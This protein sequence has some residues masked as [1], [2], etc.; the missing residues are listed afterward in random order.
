MEWKISI[1]KPGD[2]VRVKRDHY[3]HHGIYVGNGEVIHFTG[4]N[5]DGLTKPTEVLVRKTS[6]QFFLKDGVG[7][8]AIYSRKERRT[9][10]KPEEIV[11]LA[12]ERIGEGN[13]NIVSNNCEHFV[14]SV[15]FK[16]VKNTRKF[17]H[18]FHLLARIFIK[19]TGYLVFWIVIT[20][21]YFYASK[22]AKKESKKIKGGAII[23]SN[24]TSIFDYYI[25]V[26]KHFFHVIHTMVA[27]VVYSHKSLAHLCR[28]L[29][30]I[31]V[32]R[33]DPGN[34]KAYNEAKNY[35]NRG[36]TILIFPEGHLE[37]KA[38]TLE[39]MKASAIKLAFETGKPIIPYFTLGNYGLFKRTK[40]IVGEKIYV[41]EL[42][43]KNVL[44]DSDIKK[45]QEYLKTT[46]NKLKHQLNCM[47]KYK[48]RSLFSR[49][50]YLQDFLKITSIPIGYCILRARKIYIGDKKKIKQAMKE[51]VILAP[52]H[53]SM[54]DVMFMYL[55]FF[56]RRIRI[57]A[58]N[59]I[60]QVKFLA[61]NLD[62]SGVIKYNRE[63]PGGFDFA[64]YKET[65]GILEGNGAVVIFPQGHIVKDGLITET[66]KPG[67]AMHS[68]KHNAPVI[69]I[70]FAD[71]TK[72]IK[73]NRIIIGDP[74]YPYDYIDKD[75]PVNNE[76]IEK[77]NLLLTKKMQDLQEISVKYRRKA[78]QKRR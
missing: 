76:N 60:W 47:L 45:V 30:N 20:P 48:T 19:V 67:V 58:L 12:N 51:K 55:Y 36:K 69:P 4:M 31:K 59:T 32:D 75:A 70:I 46:L 13:Y 38:G 62:R 68:L 56:S 41:R 7:E 43:K 71:E 16:K 72:F 14:N 73:I 6:I 39:D 64:A 17:P 28:V 49:R 21:R 78:K 34:L 42:V 50:T 52:N 22:K 27:E 15:S 23:I 66:L 2:H 40:V 25:F 53:T 26:F 24:H 8:K 3:N 65:S 54:F 29:E 11:R 10:R 35:L 74:I 37:E 5:D 9:L 57:V 1:L 18:I 44:E 61:F 77:F 33:N 63:S